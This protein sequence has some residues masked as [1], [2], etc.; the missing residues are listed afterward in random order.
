[1]RDAQTRL[2]GRWLRQRVYTL[3]FAERAPDPRLGSLDLLAGALDGVIVRITL[4][5]RG[6]PL[7]LD[8]I[9]AC[10]CWHQFYPAPDVLPRE[11]APTLQEW[12]FVPGALPALKAGQRLVVRLASRTHHVTGVAAHE[13]LEAGA[14][15]GEPSYT[16]RDE[17]LLRSLHIQDEPGSGAGRRSLY[18]PD[19]LV[20]GT[21]R[22]E[23]FL[24]WPMGIASPG[25]MRQWGHHATAFVGRRHFD[26]PRLLEE[27]FV[28]GGSGRP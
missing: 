10:G 13:S 5:E 18:R 25:A 2:A 11:G 7:M 15:A 14:T 19:G 16:L 23:R 3:W 27:R 26:D 8:T 24:F 4:D 17:N 20:Q 28:W 6:Q 1:V 9:H 12:A 21:D 22:K